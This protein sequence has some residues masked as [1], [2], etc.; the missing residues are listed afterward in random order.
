[1]LTI[2]GIRPPGRV[3]AALLVSALLVPDTARSQFSH[4]GCADLKAGDFRKVSL[5]DKQNHSALNEPIK[6]DVARDG[7]VYWIERAGAIKVWHPGTRAVTLLGKVAVHLNDTRGAMGLALDPDFLTNGWIYIVYHPDL[8]PFERHT[9]SRFTLEDERLRDER[10]VLDIPLLAGTGNHASGA[11]AWDRDGNLLLALGDAIS[12]NNIGDFK[13][14]GYAP[15]H[16]G[17]ANLDARR[18]SGNTHDL[19]G[20]I[21]RIR[22]L[23]EGGYAIPPGNLFPPGMP[24]TRPEI[25]S[26]GHRNP[27]TLWSDPATGWLFVGEVG[28]DA[29]SSSLQRGPAAQDE[30]N[31]VKGPGNSGWPYLAG[32]NLPYNEFDFRNNVVG[33]FFNPDSLVNRSPYNTGLEILPPGV[34]S[35]IAYGHD[36]LSPDQI[37]FPVLG[38]RNRG[39]PMAGP[40]YRYDPALVSRVKLP[41]HFHGLWFIGDWERRWFLGALLDSAGGS[42]ASLREPFPG[43]TLAGFTGGLIGPEGAL[44]LIEYGEIGYSSTSATRISRVEYVG[45]CL[46]SATALR[47]PVRPGEQPRLK[48]MLDQGRIYWVQPGRGPKAIDAAGR[49]EN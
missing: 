35:L 1:M 32:A 40:V 28:A 6:M 10:T 8:P 25:Y 11:M 20:K 48:V 33:P 44:Y 17:H 14:D 36:G 38:G 22:P 34:P 21:L 16:P 12:P 39:A 42:V 23:P 3:L 24:R 30:F 49:P 29:Y 46:P 9:L 7:R 19:N 4:P 2:R 26:M 13:V 15:V 37:R 18:T 41:P 43:M 47:N 45:D 31:V 27:W 5:V